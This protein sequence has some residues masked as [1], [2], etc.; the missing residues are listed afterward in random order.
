MKQSLILSSCATLLAWALLVSSSAAKLV[1]WYP[2]D[3][4]PSEDLPVTENIAGNAA[5]LIGYD[6]DP[7]LTYLTRG[8]ASARENLGLA[9]QFDRTATAGGGLNLGN[10]MAVQPTDQ[11][12]ISFFFQPQTFDPFDRFFESLVGNS[13]D[14]H[15]L[16]I[17]LGGAGTSV[18]VLLRSNSGAN[19][20]VSHP[21]VLKNDGTWYF[22]AFRYDT[23][24]VGVDPFRVTVLEMSGDPVDEAGLAAATFGTPT[25]N[26][27]VVS[28]PHAGNSLV[29]VELPDGGNP[30]NLGAVIDEYAFFDNSD[31]NGVLSD[32]ELLDVFN[33]GPSGVELISSFATDRESISPGNPATLSWEVA[34]SLDRLT[35]EDS[36]GN[37]TDLLPLTI[38][39]SGSTTVSPSESTTYQIRA[40]RGEAANV[41]VLKIIAGAP[42]EITSL[43]ASSQLIQQGESVDLSWLVAGS[44]SLTLDPGALDVT[45][46]DTLNLTPVVTT[47]YRLSATNGFGTVTTEIPV[48]VIAGPVPI[49][50]N[51]AAIGANTESRWSDLIGNRDWS[52]T[53]GVLE[54]PLTNPSANT[55]L[56]AAYRTGGGLLGGATGT[57]SFPQ[58]SAEVWFRPGELTADHQV[59]FETGGGQNGLSALMT[60][61]A[62]RLI[63]SE[64]NERN[65]DVTIPLDGLNLGDFLQLVMTNDADGDAFTAS[66]R[67]TLGNVRIVNE[68]AQVSVGGN[69]A[70][71]FIWASGAVGT[72]HNNLG[73]R[74][75]L[76]GLSPEGLTGFAGEIAMVNV[77][78]RILDETEISQ[79]FASVA[80]GRVGPGGLQVTEI[81]FDEESDEVTLTWNS[82]NGQSYLIEFSLTLEEE[83]WIGLDDTPIA[84]TAD[85]TTRTF[86][87][88][89][90]QEKLFFRVIVAAP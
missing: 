12:T 18:R 82:L 77:Y 7:A 39:G 67:D 89:P 49:H 80:T 36:E 66:L 33:F 8:V 15:G 86:P 26:T 79:A 54:N 45:G 70:G 85:Q 31:G 56:T 13:N 46:S 21:T 4:F 34:D 29:G 44:E 41:H 78:D 40:V 24:A 69:G 59:I 74:T 63:G 42:P 73:G 83:G 61:S 28:Y 65:L 75:E 47:I 1:A 53:G 32:A 55:N 81:S 25:L 11:F 50:R 9:Y 23:N 2:L 51:V 57:F 14:A 84:A 71:L 62:V 88:P 3:E 16:R 64:L 5:T 90:N 43:T 60:E 52:L 58:L 37:T 10:G 38:A 48:E 17:D 87:V 30:N 68:S 76:A 72:S 20:Q 22:F 35:L 19:T 27:G 6:P